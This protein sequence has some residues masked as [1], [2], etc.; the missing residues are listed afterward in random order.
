MTVSDILVL[1]LYNERNP[2]FT[3][4]K[5]NINNIRLRHS[6]KNAMSV[7]SDSHLCELVKC[8]TEPPISNPWRALFIFGAICQCCQ[9]KLKE[10]SYRSIGST[11]DILIL[12]EETFCTSICLV[13]MHLHV[14]YIIIILWVCEDL[15]PL[16]CELAVNLNLERKIRSAIRRP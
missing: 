15:M 2:C 13:W 5:L 12:K 6:E 4:R 11:N 8:R 7:V 14:T 1:E 16:V 10:G 3:D 9:H